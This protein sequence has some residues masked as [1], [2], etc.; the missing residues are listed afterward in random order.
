MAKSVIRGL[1]QLQAKLSGRAADIQNN[2]LSRLLKLVQRKTLPHANIGFLETARYP[3]GTPVAAVA[4][5]NEFGTA[6]IPARPFMRQAIARNQDRWPELLGACLKQTGGNIE[7]ALD[8]ASE[9]IVSQIQQEIRSV[10]APAL[11]PSTIAAKGFE[12]PLI[13][14]AHM[15]NS[16]AHEVRDD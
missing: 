16:V 4:Y 12:K 13:D 2:M 5:Y 7:M 10:E 8:M 9:R 3:D 1:K 6:T 14:T 15:L 11:A